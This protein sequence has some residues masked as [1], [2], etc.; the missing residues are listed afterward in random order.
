MFNRSHHYYQKILCS[1]LGQR[2]QATK[3]VAHT[4]TC[5]FTVLAGFGGYSTLFQDH[6]DHREDKIKTEIERYPG[7]EQNHLGYRHD[8]ELGV[9]IRNT[10]WQDAFSVPLSHHQHRSVTQPVHSSTS[11]T[12][13]AGSSSPTLT[14]NPVF[15]QFLANNERLGREIMVVC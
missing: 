7:I 2:W 13:V 4:F 9:F 11:H 14:F 3:N 12:F 5:V 6:D 8:V 15:A 1:G 10:Q